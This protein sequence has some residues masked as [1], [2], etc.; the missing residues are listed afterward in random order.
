[1]NYQQ[2]FSTGV[3][4]DATI[5]KLSN[6]SSWSAIF[7]TGAD[8]GTAN[9]M[10]HKSMGIDMYLTLEN[11]VNEPDTTEFTIFLVS[12]KD[13]FNTNSNNFNQ[14]TGDIVLSA[15]F[16]YAVNGGLVMLNKKVFN[17]HAVKR[18]VLT[19]HGQALSASSAQ[20]QGGTDM[21]LYL[22][23][24][25]RKKIVA[26]YGNWKD[27]ACPGDPSKNYFLICFNDNSA[28]DLQNPRMKIN[29]VHTIEQLA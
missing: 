5:F 2:T 21:R 3:T 14:L 20:T 7:G 19:N 4:A 23:Y 24:S 8:D 10:V 16:H 22:K 15:G 28:L 12:L 6:I 25:P 26:P 1:M 29:V 11:T 18:R 9:S 27:I 17:I 13:E